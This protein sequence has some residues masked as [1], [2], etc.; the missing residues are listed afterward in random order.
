MSTS[1]L[2]LVIALA[3]LAGYYLRDAEVT[4]AQRDPNSPGSFGYVLLFSIIGPP[5]VAVP[6]FFSAPVAALL[7]LAA[8]PVWVLALLGVSRLIQTLQERGEPRAPR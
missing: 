4:R 2:F 7:L 6:L 1:T 8:W 3:A 5:A